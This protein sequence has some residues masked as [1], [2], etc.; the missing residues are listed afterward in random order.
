MLSVTI[1]WN[2]NSLDQMEADA[3]TVRLRDEIKVFNQQFARLESDLQI[4]ARRLSS[5]PI[6]VQALENTDED[7]LN[8]TLIAER[9]RSSLSHLRILDA[10]GKSFSLTHRRHESGFEDSLN[11]LHEL[12]LLG[13]D[14]AGL[15]Y[16]STSWML[17]V[18][19]PIKAPTD[20]LGVLSVGRVLDHQT[21]SDLNFNRADPVLML[22]DE[23]GLVNALSG[24]DL[25]RLHGEFT[26]SL[27]NPQM[28]P[29]ELRRPADSS[30]MG[31]PI[32]SES[33]TTSAARVS[34]SSGHVIEPDEAAP[35]ERPINVDYDLLVRAK[36][37]QIS[38]TT[39]DISGT[40]HRAAYAPVMLRGKPVAVFGVAL[41]SAGTND[42]RDGLVTT[43]MV[44]AG[45]VA[46][47]TLLGGYFLARI[48]S[49]PIRKLKNAAE[50][51]AMLNL[52]TP[53]DIDSRDEVG[54]LAASF[55]FMRDE[56][57]RAYSGLKQEV[58]ERMH[59]NEQLIEEIAQRQ[60]VEEELRTLAANLE[61]S[62]T[63]LEQFASIASHDLQ[64]PLR[65]I[66][67]FGDRILVGARTQLAEKHQ[68]YLD[69]LLDAAERMQVLINDLLTYSRV[70]TKANPLVPV[71]LN[72]V[73]QEVLTDL[74]STIE[75][76]MAQVEVGQLPTISADPTQMRQLLQNLI[77]NSL[78]FRK[79][80]KPPIVKIRSRHL[81]GATSDVGSVLNGCD[82]IELA[83]EDNGIGI[84]E[85]YLERVFGIFERLHSRNEFPGT[86]IGLA[87]CQ[88]IVDR[89]QGMLTVKSTVGQGSTFIATLPVDRLTT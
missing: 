22:F 75:E 33:D 70:T 87:V 9:S 45:L 1:P 71:N 61:R 63:E 13:I 19:Q 83:V 25:V 89:H 24:P 62:N 36:D 26:G 23:R 34:P 32:A 78:K 49:R 30:N 68:D 80:G 5:H 82:A 38:F 10:S 86:G 56:L 48:I 50:E 8:A 47:V 59:T 39:T 72:V 42:L 6:L 64:E 44:V 2:V 58:T 37:Q 88:K 67:T 17:V 35:P 84:D 52:D 29:I 66:R 51:I 20:S 40:P 77:S 18:V 69:R 53:I 3:S 16:T 76:A 43:S 79:D 57:Q 85:M 81:N 27:S 55:N 31:R 15:I 21:I 46:L 28:S 74:E 60:R 73:A 7:S 11:Q 14:V 54:S 12:G 65:K 4:V 41:T